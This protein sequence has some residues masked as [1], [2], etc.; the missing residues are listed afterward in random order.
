MS[1][2]CQA[3]GCVLG[4]QGRGD[5]SLFSEF[6]GQESWAGVQWEQGGVS[7]GR[8]LPAQMGTVPIVPV[9]NTFLPNETI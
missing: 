4:T 1:A 7:S 2:R 8:S 6:P 9:S 5:M 3:P